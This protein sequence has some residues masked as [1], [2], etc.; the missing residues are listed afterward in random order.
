ML[1]A[2]IAEDKSSEVLC[3]RELAAVED[4]PDYQR[5]VGGVFKVPTAQD[6]QKDG[7]R[8]VLYVSGLENVGYQ[9]NMWIPVL[10]RLSVNAAI[11][12]RERRIANELDPTYLPVYFM[13]SLRDVELLEE[14]GVRVI[15]YPANPQK[16]VQALRLHR[17]SHYCINHGESDKVVNQSKFLMAAQGGKHI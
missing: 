9:A 3:V 16:N 6:I 12:I 10:E 5:L 14:G 1:T 4:A 15:L 11:V 17:L 8:V 2:L 7:V 13:E